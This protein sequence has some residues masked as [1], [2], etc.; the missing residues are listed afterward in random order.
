MGGREGRKEGGR[1][2]MRRKGKKKKPTEFTLYFFLDFNM[3]LSK[4]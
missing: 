4:N 2:R 3:L 1:E